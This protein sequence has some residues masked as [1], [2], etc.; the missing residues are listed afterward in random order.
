MENNSQMT[1]IVSH[2]LATGQIRSNRA[3]NIAK[4]FAIAT[5]SPKPVNITAW[6]EF[7]SNSGFGHKG[8]TNHCIEPQNFVCHSKDDV[9]RAFS[10]ITSGVKRN[11]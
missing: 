4:A 5:N 11:G 6:I 10:I 3:T 9:F 8:A 7:D 1:F 2:C